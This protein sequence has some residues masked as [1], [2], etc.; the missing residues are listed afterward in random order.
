MKRINSFET[1]INESKK[2][3]KKDKKEP[4]KKATN[5]VL[6]VNDYKKTV[7]KIDDAEFEG[8]TLDEIKKELKE[9]SKELKK[10]DKEWWY[11]GS[12]EF[13]GKKYDIEGTEIREDK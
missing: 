8:T 5:V 6:Y 3:S 4:K 12:F 9:W 11:Q 7:D 1:F 10:Q 2:E 13:D